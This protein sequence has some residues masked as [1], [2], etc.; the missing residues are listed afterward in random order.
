VLLLVLLSVVVLVVAVPQPRASVAGSSSASAGVDKRLASAADLKP[1]G[2]VDVIA[3]FTPGTRMTTAEALVKAAGGRVTHDLHLIGGLGIRIKAGGALLLAE[4]PRV[5]QVQLAAPLATRSTSVASVYTKSIGAS[6]LWGGYSGVTGRNV[7]VAVID[8]GIDGALDDFR[9]SRTN[10]FSRVRASVVV[11]PAAT[12]AE[13]GYGHG[14]HVAGIIAGD[15]SNRRIS[16]SSRGRYI[17]VA[18]DARLISVKI[19]DDEG[20]ATTLDAIYG[21]QFAVDHADEL[22]IRII[23]LSLASSV[24][25]SPRTDPLAAAAEA[26]WFKG[27]VVVAAAGNDGEAPNAVSYA[28]GND[29]YVITVG[30]TDDHGTEDQ[31]DDDVPDWSSQGET[32]QGY[33]KPDVLAPGAHIIS[34]LAPDSAF[35]DLCP[36][37]IVD[38]SYFQAG[39]TSMAA[40]V[41]SGAAALLLERHPDWTPDQVKAALKS[42]GT[43]SGEI[44]TEVRVDKAISAAPSRTGSRQTWTTNKLISSVTREINYSAAAW[45]AAAWRVA[46]PADPFRASWAA[47]S[48][49][50]DC[51]TT[52]DGSI[53]PQA[54]AW[55]AASWRTSFKK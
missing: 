48:W 45:R 40:A 28:P 52:A 32:Q 17:G 25:E 5:Q 54:A 46:D 7:G 38:R 35:A 12:N 43:G 39:G 11:N 34:T 27:L 16:D 41:V 44:G 9:V 22:G 18:P 8:T 26:A 51:S 36:E 47:A 15:G 6:K 24:A 50:C 14:T 31:S 37:C 20:R 3:R 55:R 10:R 2:D 21:I 42:T 30:A 29:P 53:D 19:S 49:R 33:S 4:D 23:N 1:Y 13:D